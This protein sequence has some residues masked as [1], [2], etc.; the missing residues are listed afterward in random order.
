MRFSSIALAAFLLLSALSVPAVADA[1]LSRGDH[2]GTRASDSDNASRTRGLAGRRDNE[3]ISR[4]NDRSSDSLWRKG[5]SEGA[6]IRRHSANRKKFTNESGGEKI[7]PVN[8][9]LVE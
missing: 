4:R 8:P 1:P 6:S 3:N 5:D 9:L 2:W 7:T